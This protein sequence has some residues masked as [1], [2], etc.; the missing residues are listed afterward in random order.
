[1]QLPHAG[2]MP[3]DVKISPGRQDLLRRRHDGQRRLDRST[4]TRSRDPALLPTGKGAHGLYVSRDSTSCTS[5]T[6]ARARISVLDFA[7]GKLVDEVAAPRR[8]QPRHGRRLRRRQ[9]AVALRPLRRRGLRDRHDDGHLLARIPVGGDRTASASTRS[10]AATRSA[11]PASSARSGP[12][13]SRVTGPPGPPKQLRPPRVVGE[14]QRHRRRDQPAEREDQVRVGQ[15]RTAGRRGWWRCSRRCAGALSPPRFLA[16]PWIDGV[17]DLQRS[18][19]AS[20]GRRVGA[21]AGSSRGR[22]GLP[23]P[24]LPLEAGAPGSDGRHGRQVC[25][26]GVPSA[27]TSCTL[28]TRALLRA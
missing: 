24:G 20:G 2:A 8:R 1:M 4:A 23:A 10:P 25:T 6:A 14:H 21:R 13:P 11:T 27:L 28:I 22:G 26:N 9:G 12:L 5:P 17:P 19:L 15:R 7:T 18:Y 16:L 3:Q